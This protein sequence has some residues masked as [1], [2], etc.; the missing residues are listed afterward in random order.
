M[1]RE[2]AA[3][4]KVPHLFPSL[5]HMEVPAMCSHYSTAPAG[6]HRTGSLQEERKHSD[7]Q[8]LNPLNTL[9]QAVKHLWAL[10]E[11]LPN[12]NRLGTAEIQ[13]LQICLFQ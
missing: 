3:D 9:A 13:Q 12:A 5:H 6:A 4:G 8:S 10:E 7:Q 11:A 2:K 1:A